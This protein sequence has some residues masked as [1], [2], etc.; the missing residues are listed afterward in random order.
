MPYCSINKAEKKTIGEMEQEFLQ[1]MQVTLLLNPQSFFFYILTYLSRACLNNCCFVQSF[2]YDGKAIMSNEEFDN[3]KEELMWEGS[4]VVML[5]KSTIINI[6]FFSFFFWFLIG[7]IVG[8]V[9]WNRR[10]WWT[11]ILGSFNGLCFWESN[12]QWSRIWSAQTQTKGFIPFILQ[13]Q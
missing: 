6:F 4:S 9:M 11:K 3:L 10:F 1:A 2:Y 5:S 8:L 7:F 12:P 13:T